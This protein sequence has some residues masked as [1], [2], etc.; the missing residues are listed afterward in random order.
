MAAMETQ[1]LRPASAS[2]WL[3]RLGDLVIST[4][5]DSNLVHEATP[6][7][8]H[9]RAVADV[10]AL[11]STQRVET[12]EAHARRLREENARLQERCAR[13]S[14][15]TVPQSG[16]SEMQTLR[17]QAA[18][19][20][21]KATKLRLDR[22]A[23]EEAAKKEDSRSFRQLEQRVLSQHRRLARHAKACEVDRQQ[24]NTHGVVQGKKK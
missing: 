20:S 4:P 23:L 19:L 10:Q 18:A 15:D 3:Q 17:T 16:E 7:T 8:V 22:A 2:A 5:P 24:E 14:D 1:R 13:A 21:R 6:A 9:D 12:L 11:L